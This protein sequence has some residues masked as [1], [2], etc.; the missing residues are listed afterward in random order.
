[1]TLSSFS[2]IYKIVI[3]YSRVAGE[4]S[5]YYLVYEERKN[6]SLNI[7]D[8]GFWVSHFDNTQVM[9]PQTL[10]T[11]QT[12]QKVQLNP[13]LLQNFNLTPTNPK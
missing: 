10:Q 4:R 7:I 12:G 8:I 5:F 3:C 6:I 11:V 1:M 9:L 13:Q 2:S